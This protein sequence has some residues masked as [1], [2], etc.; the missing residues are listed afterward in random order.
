MSKNI[1][2]FFDRKLCMKEPSKEAQEIWAKLLSQKNYRIS[3]LDK[4]VLVVQ[5]PLHIC[6]KDQEIKLC[7][8]LAFVKTSISNKDYVMLRTSSVFRNI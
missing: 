5:S 7:N 2:L 8:R 4:Y 1:S 3:S 6:L